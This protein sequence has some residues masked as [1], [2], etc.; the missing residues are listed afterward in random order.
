[1]EIGRRTF[2][3]AGALGSIAWWLAACDDSGS[4]T[5][6]TER[7]PTPAVES[8][9]FMPGEDAPHAATWMCF[10]GRTD[11]WGSELPDVQAA[12][13]DLGLTIAEFEPV[14]MLVRPGDLTIAEDLLGS[15]IELIAAPVDDLWA[16]DTLPL[17]LVTDD[18]HL[19]AGRVRF[20]GWG[21]KQVHDGDEQLAALVA[22]VL[23]IELVDSGVVG[24]GG[25][26]ETDG[27]GTL[28]AARSSWVN[29]NRN[30]GMPEDE[31]ADRLV[32]LLGADRLLW[33]DGVA[34]ADITDG[35]IDTLA[36][37][38]DPRTIVHEFPSYVDPGETWYDLAVDTAAEL[39]AV[40][41]LDG[42]PYRLVRLDQPAT[43]RRTGDEFLAS[44]VNYYVCNGAV[45][46]SQY[47]DATA[48]GRAAEL[49]GELHPGR[50]V[51]AV[52]F[53]P[54]AAGGGGV[55]CA[56]QQEPAVNSRR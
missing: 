11:V 54:V 31:I 55:H 53:D 34:G 28:L 26:V 50:Q 56:T 46:V 45:I 27:D 1:M 41:T 35:H 5:A 44:Y 42:E 47:G 36:R 48:D 29:D 43:Q 21:G 39:D 40:T 8:G 33:V 51:V 32:A 16:R 15:D 7:P 17:F 30:P 22:D 14:R 20:N 10:P 24:E 18:G 49:I 52:D 13:A 38:V 19:A 12:I 9:R 37:F 2:L 25:G 4:P 23:G 3:G 6:G